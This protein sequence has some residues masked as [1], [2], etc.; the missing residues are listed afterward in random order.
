[1]L[2]GTPVSWLSNAKSK[3]ADAGAERVEVLKATFFALIWSEE[4]KFWPR[5]SAKLSNLPSQG[6]LRTVLEF[7]EAS[8]EGNGG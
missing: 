1:M 7:P 5:A 3:R 8:S 6:V 2:W 4:L